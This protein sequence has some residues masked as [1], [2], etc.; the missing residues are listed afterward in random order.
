MGIL[1]LLGALEVKAAETYGN[2][3]TIG[4]VLDAPKGVASEQIRE[5]RLFHVQKRKSRRLLDPVQVHNY[6]YYAGSVFG[7]Q[8]GTEYRFRAEFLG[9]GEKVFHREEFNGRTRPEPREPPKARREIHVAKNGNDANPGTASQPKRT[10]EAALKN[11][12]QAGTHV[13]LHGGVYYE[14]N[15]PAVETI[16]CDCN[17]FQSVITH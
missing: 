11:A 8:P 4:V 6:S 15:L 16:A 17:S 12:N 7:L 2:F 14:G 10:L 13:I 1:M 3:H 9:A 5:V